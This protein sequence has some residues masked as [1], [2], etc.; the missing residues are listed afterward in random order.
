MK[1]AGASS[2]PVWSTSHGQQIPAAA[3]ARLLSRYEGP[4]ISAYRRGLSTMSGMS[5]RTDSSSVEVNYLMRRLEEK[6]MDR[7]KIQMDTLY[8]KIEDRMMEQ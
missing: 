3:T 2:H 4:P 5:P 8:Q 1:Y 7:M 6:I